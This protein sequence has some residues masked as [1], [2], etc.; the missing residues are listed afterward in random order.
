MLKVADFKRQLKPPSIDS[1]Q[2]LIVVD[3]HIWAGLGNGDISVWD[4]KVRIK[5]LPTLSNS[6]QTYTKVKDFKTRADRIYVL[7][8][9]GDTVWCSSGMDFIEV[10]HKRV[11]FAKLITFVT[12]FNHFLR[13]NHQWQ[14]Q[15][16]RKQSS[17]QCYQLKIK[18]LCRHWKHY[19]T[20]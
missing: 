20:T 19:S 11:R 14:R 16:R 12:T 15:M 18:R 3:H 9:V 4:R 10:F 6:A 7:L 5:V 13:P 1:V 17:S 8:N 2:E